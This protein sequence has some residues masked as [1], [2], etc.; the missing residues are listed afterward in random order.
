MNVLAMRRHRTIRQVIYPLTGLALPYTVDFSSLGNGGLPS[1]WR[2]ATWTILSGAATNTPTLGTEELTDQQPR[3]H[4]GAGSQHGHRICWRFECFQR[5][6]VRAE[7]RRG[8]YLRLPGRSGVCVDRCS[9]ERRRRLLADPICPDT[10]TIQ[11]T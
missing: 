4:Q 7:R 9:G 2:G 8:H 1:P 11:L 10:P 6:R 3:C 5:Q